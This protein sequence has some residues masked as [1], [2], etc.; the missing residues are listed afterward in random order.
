MTPIG[1]IAGEVR[2][3]LDKL[4]VSDLDESFLNRKKEGP[5]KGGIRADSTATKKGGSGECEW[6]SPGDKRNPRKMQL[7]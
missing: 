1:A 3:S 4:R 5:G 6:L 2:S 7:E